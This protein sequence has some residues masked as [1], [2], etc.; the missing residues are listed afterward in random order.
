MIIEVSVPVPVHSEYDYHAGELSP[1]IQIGMRVYV[2]FGGKNVVGFVVGIK[3]ASEHPSLKTIHSL[4]DQEP[5][6]TA[7]QLIFA[8]WMS[9]Y[10]QSS[11][12]EV[13]QAFFPV[14]LISKEEEYITIKREPDNELLWDHQILS[15]FREQKIWEKK[16]L[17]KS[18]TGTVPFQTALQHLINDGTLGET[19]DIHQ[20]HQRAINKDFWSVSDL[21]KL[22]S[23]RMISPNQKVFK[24]Y[25]LKNVS[26]LVSGIEASIVQEECRIPKTAYQKFIENGVLTVT[27]RETL[28]YEKPS[29]EPNKPITFTDEQLNAWFEM[30]SLIGKGGFQPMLL[31]GITGSG[32]TFL[33]IE[34]LK[35]I[36]AQGKSGII[37]VPEISLTP[38]TLGRFQEHFGE[39]IGVIHSK[40]SESERYL[41]WRKILSGEIRIVIGPRSAL[42]S[43]VQNLGLIIVD[44]EHDSSYKQY[45]PSP[46]Y[47]ARDSAIYRSFLNKCPIILGS[48]TPS[49]ES[50]TQAKNGKYHLVT[51]KN[52]ADDANLPVVRVLDVKE[53]K[54]QNYYDGAV[55]PQLFEAIR[56]RLDK[57]EG[58]ILLQN[59]RGFS[60]YIECENCDWVD[61][62]PNCS[63]T[64]TFHKMT[65]EMRCHY[66]G[67]SNKP[68][69]GCPKCKSH[70]LNPVGAGT[71]QLEDILKE[72][73]PDAN[74]LRMDQDSISTKTA[75]TK[76]L[77]SFKNNP[78]SILLGT[79]M[80]A[81]GLD[82]HHVTLVGVIGA[83]T[84]L[85]MADFRASERTYQLLSQVAGRSGRGKL[86]G[87]VL[88]QTHHSDHPI[89]KYVIEHD[90][91][92]FYDS[93]IEERQELNYPPYSRMIVVEVKSKDQKEA[94]IKIKETYNK[95]LA[96]FPAQEMKGPVDPV[97]DR[98]GGWFRQHI[99]IFLPKDISLAQK[100]H[101]FFMSLQRDARDHWKNSARLIIDVDYQ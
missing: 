69:D 91:V 45:E 35:E 34:A 24:D 52:R 13:L 87:E 10:Y 40:K 30:K 6:L 92:G 78:K 75:H 73:F 55:S 50:Y 51:L 74:V 60:N 22:E 38:Q 49:F 93:Q 15:W 65:R 53:E 12:G 42:F 25:I 21:T 18:Y 43:P 54:K 16:A 83:D 72:K 5:V 76:I 7:E 88:I 99:F 89:F 36:L 11:L 48:A 26:R 20:T 37:L 4:L 94:K 58:V 70:L 63:V 66:C 19:K 1:H 2:P 86:A 29:H 67:Y 8:E 3:T 41:T 61:E 27:Q 46:R 33:Y 44:E 47:N 101:S 81:K 85:L 23:M 100:Y 28:H 80:I 59:R 68:Y 82:F 57:N 77:K 79:Q 32:K 84:G 39:K 14:N 71:Q 31:F 98:M 17:Q 90:F 97:I 95:L 96:C 9:S 64:L 56:S 62:C